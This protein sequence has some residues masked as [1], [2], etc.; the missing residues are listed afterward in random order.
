MSHSLF[1]ALDR[2]SGAARLMV[3]AIVLAFLA[4]CAPSDPLKSSGIE[5]ITGTLMADKPV[6]GL[7]YEVE[8]TGEWFP[9]PATQ[10]K[11]WTSLAVARKTG[12]LAVASDGSPSGSLWTV[13]LGQSWAAVP[14]T[15]SPQ[16][17]ASVALNDIGTVGLAAE[18]NGA[19]WRFNG[20]AWTKAAET[21]GKQW[22]C[23]AVDSSGQWLFAA[24]KSGALW[25]FDAKD[26]KF[27]MSSTLSTGANPK[28]LRLI[29]ISNP[30]N[31]GRTES[32]LQIP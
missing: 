29:Y 23:M 18:K 13:T 20:L 9:V 6:A 10:G 15:V 30:N 11:K 32:V 16:G 31:G 28:V 7:R 12:S 4:A 5:S 1:R 19:L 25:Y 14:A 26:A 21:S 27:K 22:C 3:T 24:E 2:A 8:A 17:W